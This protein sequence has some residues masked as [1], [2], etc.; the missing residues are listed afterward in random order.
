MEYLTVGQQLDRY[1][2]DAVVGSGGMGIVYRGH[3]QTLQSP[4]AIK[5]L[6]PRLA[7]DTT[8]VRRFALEAQAAATLQHPNIVKVTDVGQK[9]GL[10][11]LIMEFLPG[12]TLDRWLR[13]RG[14]AT[15][16][17]TVNIVRQ[18]AAALDHAHSHDLIHR[19]VKPANIMLRGDGHVTLMDFGLAR[20]G[21]GIG[22]TL[23]HQI[24]GTPEYLSPEQ[25][26]G[27]R[28]DRRSDIYALGIVTY[29]MLT[30]TTPFTGTTPVEIIRMH[31]QQTPPPLRTLRA[32]IPPKL[33]PV[34]TRV[35]AKQPDQRFQSAGEF[36][37]RLQE[38][39]TAR[40][41]PSPA[42]PI[43]LPTP[44]PTPPKQTPPRPMPPAQGD[45]LPALIW[46]VIF[47]LL[48][49]VV[50]LFMVFLMTGR[51]PVVW[52]DPVQASLWRSAL[53]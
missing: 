11:Y 42:P 13:E 49:V 50:V 4:V 35:L 21:D 44:N 43:T 1:I 16:P 9:G 52:V 41:A 18:M 34:M 46:I 47:L 3:H 5:V 27:Q 38:A 24:L 2:V 48:F 45:L 29:R 6:D 31:I 14:Y 37:H 25:A 10:Y 32:E 33:E 12:V 7:G 40:D 17:E 28:G 22:L 36:S 20:A 26:Q 53:L 23:P 51:L 15:L 8:F 19:D 30:G 39:A